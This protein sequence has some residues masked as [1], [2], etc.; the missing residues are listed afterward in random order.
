[1]S[2]AVVELDL[3]EWD[4]L[5]KKMFA[6][7]GRAQALL[8]VSAQAYAFQDIIQHFADEMGPKGKWPDWSDS[9][10]AV[11]AKLGWLGNKKLQANGG[12]RMSLLP[13]NGGIE[14]V[15]ADAIRLFTNKEYSAIHNYGGPFLAWGKHPAVMP[16]RE[17]MWLSEAVQ[18]KMVSAIAQMIL[19]EGA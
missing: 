8:R 7:L 5:L 1:V 18:D 13:E 19:E 11:Y 3:S 14:N 15:G 2:E 9:T 4:D 10:K 12:L 17:F 6:N 16:Q